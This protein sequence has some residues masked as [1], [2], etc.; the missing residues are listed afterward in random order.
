MP[1]RNETIRQGIEESLGILGR[2]LNASIV[3]QNLVCVLEIQHRNRGFGSFLYLIGIQAF[4]DP[5]K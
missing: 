2:R 3:C 1:L 4:L 5:L